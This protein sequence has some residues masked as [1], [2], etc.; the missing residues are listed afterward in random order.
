MGN[1]EGMF[2]LSAE[3]EGETLEKEIDFVKNEIVK[4]LGEIS[5][6]KTLGRRQLAYPIRKMKDGIYLL[7]N[8]AA[9]PDIIDSF[10]KRLRLNQSLLRAMVFRKEKGA[11]LN[12]IRE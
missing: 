5:E 4:Q 8:F 7:I 2:I 11:Q 3:L 9:K 12:E 10:L 6:A 1:Y